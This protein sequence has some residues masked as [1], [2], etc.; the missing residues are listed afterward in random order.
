MTKKYGGKIR[1]TGR[2]AKK[3][4][5]SGQVLA[6]KSNP[7]RVARVGLNT[8]STRFF[9]SFPTKMNVMVPLYADTRYPFPFANSGS[10]GE[11]LTTCNFFFLDPLNFDRQI[12]DNGHDAN[13]NWF[14]PIMKQLF[15]VFGEGRV[16]T[17]V[18]K[19]EITCEYSKTYGL[20]PTSTEV[21]FLY[22][23]VVQLACASVPLNYLK[24]NSG[25]QFAITDA[26]QLW[27][28][29]DY[30]SAL[31]QM[32]GAKVYQIPISGDRK[33]Q[34]GQLIIDGYDHDGSAQ[35]I[36]STV[37]WSGTGG[38]T[39]P[40]ANITYPPTET[41]NV[42][43]FAFRTRGIKYNNCSQIMI[44]RFSLKLETHMTFVDSLPPMPF[45]TNGVS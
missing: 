14:S 22:E 4:Q 10:D 29:V 16:R 17:S 1:R 25:S 7:F 2:S 33:A 41:R 8:Y 23:P 30:F 42:F 21:N 11:A 6:V 24:K 15:T 39:T 27:L 9:P 13:K 26:G 19:Y 28:G 12:S 44:P 35:L 37:T 3:Y 38:P 18:L 36:R 20:S 5:K 31:T 43:L 34:K 32:P 40:T 45:V